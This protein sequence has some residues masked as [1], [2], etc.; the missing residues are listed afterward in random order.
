MRSR[1]ARR[2]ESPALVSAG[3]T[4]EA[5]GMAS[6][7]DSREFN[8][9]LFFARPDV[10]P[11]PAHAIDFEVTTEVALHVRW[12]RRRTELPT[13][14]LFHGN[15]EVVADYDESADRFADVGVNLAVMDYRGYGRSAGNPTLRTALADAHGVLDAVRARSGTPLIVMGRSLG[16]ACA[17]ELYASSPASVGGF[18]LESGF[19]DLGALIRRR[20]LTMPAELSHEELAAFDPIPKL[21][22]GNR[23]L[24]VLHGANDTMI[25]VDE[26]QRAFG[27]AGAQDKEL[28]VIPNRGHNDVS[29]EVRYWEALAKLVA[30]VR[31]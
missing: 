11:P 19:V 24:L 26:A 13:L 2:R 16:S 14:L 9:R 27:A 25:A 6:L 22:R 29:L 3:A 4:C 20:G 28:V 23:P 5:R 31:G 15:G 1:A 10:T 30:R 8:Q 12:H 17:N 7:F 18:V 21:A